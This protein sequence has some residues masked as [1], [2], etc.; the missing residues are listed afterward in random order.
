MKRIL[1][2]AMQ[3][4]IALF[5]ISCSSG[6]VPEPVKPDPKPD[7]PT[8]TVK[9]PIKISMGSLTKVTDSSF[10]PNDAVGIYVVNYNGANPGTLASTGNHVNNMKFVYSTTWT[11]NEEIYWK[12][13][14]T[15]ADFYAFYPYTTV[16]DVT[17]HPFNLQA[18][19]STVASYKASEFLWGKTSKVAPT[20]S[21]VGITANRLLSNAIIKLIP[22]N[23][24]TQSE[25]DNSN[26]TVKLLNV[27]TQSRIN[28]STGIATAT[29]NATSIQ[30]LD[31]GSQFRALVVPQTIAS[32]VPIAAV[33]IAGQTYTLQ[34][35]KEVPFTANKKLTL[36]VTLDKKANGVDIGI[37]EWEED[38]I[39]YGGVAE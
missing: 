9:L 11:P 5:V 10:E 6:E 12:D 30:M 18:D 34:T 7:K 35:T 25:I 32:G 15:P 39:D 36:T 1:S 19:Q 31:E 17:S 24:F 14:T 23:G 26:A 27:Q 21:A 13:N 33:T 38:D 20:E 3:L 29:G 8:E 22:G 2:Y 37:G 4:T 28:L 16:S